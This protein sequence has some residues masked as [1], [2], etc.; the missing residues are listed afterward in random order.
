MVMKGTWTITGHWTGS[1]LMAASFTLNSPWHPLVTSHKSHLSSVTKDRLLLAR[2]LLVA[3]LE[4]TNCV[5][6]GLT[7][8]VLVE[9]DSR[10]HYASLWWEWQ[11]QIFFLFSSLTIHI[12]TLCADHHRHSTWVHAVQRQRCLEVRTPPQE[13]PGLGHLQ[14]GGCWEPGRVWIRDWIFLWRWGKGLWHDPMRV[15]RA[16]WSSCLGGCSYL[17]KGLFYLLLLLSFSSSSSSLTSTQILCRSLRRSSPCPCYFPPL[18]SNFPLLEYTQPSFHRYPHS[19][20]SASSAAPHS[21]FLFLY[22]LYSA[23]P[24]HDR[25]CN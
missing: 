17:G 1:V 4:M 19:L 21:L 20:P 13:S 7:G 24:T 5:Y 18:I 3:Q 2:A 11:A 10:D 6:R 23:L 14:S 15:S 8:V 16:L 12:C 25:L 9:A 22:L